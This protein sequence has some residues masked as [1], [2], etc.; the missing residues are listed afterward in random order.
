MDSI[1]RPERGEEI[2]VRSGVLTESSV[3]S[4]WVPLFARFPFALSLSV[5][6]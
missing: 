6:D 3:V 2:G 5:F 4:F 1:N